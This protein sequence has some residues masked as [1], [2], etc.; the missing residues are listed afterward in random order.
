MAV[1]EQRVEQTVSATP[2]HLT[3][4]AMPFS[5]VK[6]EHQHRL[7]ILLSDTSEAARKELEALY[8]A[9]HRAF[10][11]VSAGTTLVTGVFLLAALFLLPTAETNSQLS[12]FLW[13][14][15]L[16]TVLLV[17]LS[18]V[19]LSL[20]REFLLFSRVEVSQ[21]SQGIDAAGRRLAEVIRAAS[22]VHENMALDEL[23]KMEF[24]VRLQEAENLL[25]LIRLQTKKQY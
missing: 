15:V 1:A 9:K 13:T 5:W 14:T 19:G 8:T 23:T 24:D 7:Q 17:G 4:E 3:S 2:R 18:V 21:R 10:V 6:P 16:L 11:V 20:Q 25:E 12:P 22:A